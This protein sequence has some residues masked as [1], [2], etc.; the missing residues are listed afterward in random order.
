MIEYSY[1]I[2]VCNEHRELETLLR[3]LQSHTINRSK[4][5]IVVLVDT[6]N[7]TDDVKM[8]IERNKSFIKVF[9]R[10]FDNN[11]ANHKN[12]LNS[13][14]SGKYIFNIDADEIPN[15]NIFRFFESLKDEVFDVVYI[16]R[17]NI[18]PGH[19]QEF[20]KMHNF[21]ANEQGWINWPD[22]QG[23]IYPAGAVWEG[24]VHEKIKGTNVKL[25]NPDPSFAIMHIKSMERQNRQNE[26]YK[27][28][29]VPDQ[30]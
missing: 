12:F 17:I 26:L 18:C 7:V 11:F 28:I 4:T 6:K 19:T 27:S 20:L 21:T 3:H 23:R 24:D 9:E 25:L 10:D 13:K 16:P 29:E 22:F 15:L 5:E 8:V 1:A 30:E 14:C 2:C